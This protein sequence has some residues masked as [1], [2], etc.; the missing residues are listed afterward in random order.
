MNVNPHWNRKLPY[1]KIQILPLLLTWNAYIIF[2]K[3]MLKVMKSNIW[4]RKTEISQHFKPHT[5]KIES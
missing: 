2:S 3:L 5:R 4:R 1:I